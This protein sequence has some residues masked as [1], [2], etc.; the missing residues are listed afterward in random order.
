M[1][2]AGVKRKCR[3]RRRISLHTG[4]TTH[5][6]QNKRKQ[7]KLY[8]RMRE[9]HTDNNHQTNVTEYNR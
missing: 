7:S 9:S 5:A 1:V 3:R 8:R 4:P 2:A 6:A